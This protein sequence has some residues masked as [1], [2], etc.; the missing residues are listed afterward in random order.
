[1]YTV[2][3]SNS[4]GSTM[5]TADG[6]E[7]PSGQ[8]WTSGEVGNTYAHSDEFGSISFRDLADKHISGDTGETWGVLITYGGSH[9]VGRYEGGGQLKVTFDE[10][11]QAHVSGMNLR[12]VQLWP[13]IAEGEL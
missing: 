13:L 2:T 7:I 12:H 11:L 1:M 10:H 3:I 6:K 8:S 5:T 9:M 4:T